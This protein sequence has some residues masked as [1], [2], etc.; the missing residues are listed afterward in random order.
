MSKSIT[1]QRKTT[2]YPKPI[3][4]KM[5]D[6][7]KDVLGGSISSHVN[8]ALELWYNSMTEKEKIELLEKAKSI[9]NYK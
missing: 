4:H 9:K 6:A 8:K 2:V 1:Q 5:L 3:Y 7:S